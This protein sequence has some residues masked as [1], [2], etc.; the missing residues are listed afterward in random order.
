MIKNEFSDRLSKIKE[1]KSVRDKRIYSQFRIEGDTFHFIRHAEKNKPRSAGDVSINK[2][3]QAYLTKK[4]INTTILHTE[5][6]IK[7]RVRAP[8]LAILIAT[9]FYEFEKKNA[10]YERID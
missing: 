8:S 5:C 1:A 4:K 3:W 9:G 2:L 6:D 10:Y 7:G